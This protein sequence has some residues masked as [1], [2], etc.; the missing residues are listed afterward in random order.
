MQTT[1]DM[2]SK[3]DR[4]MT[5]DTSGSLGDSTGVSSALNPHWIDDRHKVQRPVEH[6]RMHRIRNAVMTESQTRRLFLIF[7]YLSLTQWGKLMNKS[8]DMVYCFEVM[9]GAYRKQRDWVDR[10]IEDTI[11]NKITDLRIEFVGGTKGCAEHN[12]ATSYTYTSRSTRIM[13]ITVTDFTEDTVTI[14]N[15]SHSASYVALLYSLIV[16]GV[17]V[18][19]DNGEKIT[20]GYRHSNI[21]FHDSQLIPPRICIDGARACR[22]CDFMAELTSCLS[23]SRPSEGPVVEIM[24]VQDHVIVS[25][26]VRSMASRG[27]R[28]DVVYRKLILRSC[29][30]KDDHPQHVP[31]RNMIVEELKLVDCTSNHQSL[32]FL[33]RYTAGYVNSVVMI[34]TKLSGVNIDEAQQSYMDVFLGQINGAV[35]RVAKN[36]ENNCKRHVNNTSGDRAVNILE[37]PELACLKSVDIDH[38]SLIPIETDSKDEPFHAMTPCGVTRLKVSGCVGS[39]IF[40]K[41]PLSN[42]NGTAL[43]PFDFIE[44]LFFRPP[45]TDAYYYSGDDSEYTFN[46]PLWDDMNGSY[47]TNN[48]GVKVF[49]F[50]RVRDSSFFAKELNKVVNRKTGFQ[51]EGG[52]K[53]ENDKV[54]S[55][56]SRR[57]TRMDIAYCSNRLS[58]FRAPLEI[59]CLELCSVSH[60]MIHQIVDN[61]QRRGKPLSRLS[62]CKCSIDGFVNHPIDEYRIDVISSLL[63]LYTGGMS[64]RHLVINH[65][66]ISSR[67][68]VSMI[69]LLR[70]SGVYGYPKL[71]ELDISSNNLTNT[72]LCKLFNKALATSQLPPTQNT[73]I[74]GCLVRWVSVGNAYSTPRNSTG[75]SS[76]DSS[77]VRVRSKRLTVF[78]MLDEPTLELVRNMEF[79][80]EEAI[81][82]RPFLE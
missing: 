9:L 49:A 71:E 46:T 78:D 4:V 55:I 63:Q 6:V 67:H 57:A 19:R 32:M 76:G 38:Y 48:N 14:R 64:V 43:E 5:T 40:N 58:I 34:D 26:L 30:M 23:K 17:R 66:K 10:T 31:L 65:C 7:G 11:H 69:A 3:T 39:E 16:E 59:Q 41:P 47:G 56:V 74:D 37:E 2:R 61:L 54:T 33:S 20:C 62:L 22:M 15:L 75:A 28:P 45:E 13:N 36:V 70:L 81:T 79:Y 24:N 12:I 50:P 53:I 82:E 18:I 42:S 52:K 1:D 72:D 80:F 27:D 60:F 21:F 51:F 68:V 77:P 73:G 8:V 35:G 44:N 29:T 25:N